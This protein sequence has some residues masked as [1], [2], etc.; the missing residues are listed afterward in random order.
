MEVVVSS[1]VF[2]AVGCRWRTVWVVQF[3]LGVKIRVVQMV[4]RNARVNASLFYSPGNCSGDFPVAFSDVRI[5]GGL[6]FR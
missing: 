2:V 3:G 6:Y 4:S 1:F 5:L